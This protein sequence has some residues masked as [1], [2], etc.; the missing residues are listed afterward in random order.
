MP[1]SQL[2]SAQH[3]IIAWSKNADSDTARLVVQ[4]AILVRRSMEPTDR[5]AASNIGQPIPTVGAQATTTLNEGYWV[6]AGAY[7]CAPLYG[8]YGPWGGQQ[9]WAAIPTAGIQA[10][11]T[12]SKGCWLYCTLG[13]SMSGAYRQRPHRY[14]R[15]SI[16]LPSTK[17]SILVRK[18]Q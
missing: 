12:L 9:Y 15:T 8:A 5:G 13:C 14:W 11:T 6:F 18:K 7:S 16:L 2:V 4:A 17:T 3:G 1:G 10:T